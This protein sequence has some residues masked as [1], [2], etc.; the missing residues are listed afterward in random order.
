MPQASGENC[1]PNFGDFKFSNFGPEADY[2][3]VSFAFFQ[4]FQARTVPYLG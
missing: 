4:Y 1:N 2:P 3:E